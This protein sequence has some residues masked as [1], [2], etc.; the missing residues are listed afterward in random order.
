MAD[1]SREKRKKGRP[2]AGRDEKGRPVPVSSTY[3]QTT[4]RLRPTIKAALDA[5]ALIQRDDRSSIIE[6]ALEELIER[7]PAED[8]AMV[9]KLQ[10][11]ATNPG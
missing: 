9:R 1:A 2:P 11:R 7:L 10:R 5:L 6:R 3:K 4:V 8:Q